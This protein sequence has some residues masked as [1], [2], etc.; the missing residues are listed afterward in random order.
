MTMGGDVEA[1]KLGERLLFDVQVEGLGDVW[2]SRHGFWRGLMW[3]AG[4]QC[5]SDVGK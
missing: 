2:M 3:L 4:T 1:K 5:S